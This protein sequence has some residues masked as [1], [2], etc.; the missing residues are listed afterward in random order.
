MKICFP[1]VLVILLAGSLFGQSLDFF[2]GLTLNQYY[3]F[4]KEYVY[5]P[6]SFETGTGFST[7]AGFNTR[8]NSITGTPIRFTLRFQQ[9]SGGFEE[10]GG[11]LGFRFSNKCHIQTQSLGIG[12][13]PA[14]LSLLNKRLEL[15]LGL[16]Y[17]VILTDHLTGTSYNETSGSSSSITPLDEN[18]RSFSKITGF[19]FLARV[20]YVVELEGGWELFPQYSFYWGLSNRFFEY[21]YDVKNM[22]HLFEIGIRKKLKT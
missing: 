20:A 9:Y 10:K 8:F 12:I 15:G 4:T 18:K 19:G 17:T 6:T 2:N 11:G 1:T 22:Q 14:D 13:F 21:V 7:G 16:E 5:Y 3:N